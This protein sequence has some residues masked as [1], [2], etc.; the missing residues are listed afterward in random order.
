MSVNKYNPYVMVLPEDDANRQIAVGFELS[1]N[2]KP[3]S[4]QV[5]TSAGG[6]KKVVEKFEKQHIPVLENDPNRHVV[7]VLDFDCD[8]NRFTSIQQKIPPQYRDRVF[9]VGAWSEPEKLRGSLGDYESIGSLLVDECSDETSDTFP[10]WQHELLVHNQGEL[11]RMQRI[12][13]PILFE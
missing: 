12:L 9:V 7:L 6:W 2:L 10:T 4:F 1:L 13:N 5:L 8:Q 11:I 3:R